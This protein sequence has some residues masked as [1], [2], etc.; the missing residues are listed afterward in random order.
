MSSRPRRKTGSKS[1]APAKRTAAG[2]STRPAARSSAARGDGPPPLTTPTPV[3]SIGPIAGTPPEI[4]GD[5]RAHDGGS[6][7]TTRRGTR[8]RGR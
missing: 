2:R 5:T 8:G 7:P 6:A 1:T 3:D 4:D